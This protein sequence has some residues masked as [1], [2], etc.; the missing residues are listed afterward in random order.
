MKY[1]TII[2]LEV[3]VELKTE[4]KLCCGCSTKF[5]A[6]PNT[7]TCPVCLGLPGAL[8]VLNKKA[9]DLGITAGLA[10]NCEI[11][12]ESKFDRKQYFYPD[13]P[14][15]YQ[16]TQFYAPIC[17]TGWLE[18]EFPTGRRRIG[19]TRI[20]LEE[21]AG[22]SYHS[23]TGIIDSDYSLLDYNRSSIPL[24][25]IVTAPDLRSP[26][27]AKEFME[28]LKIILEY[29]G[30]SDCKMEEG[31]LR[32]DA[33]I[34]VRRQGDREL[35]KRAEVKNMNSFRAVEAALEYEAKRQIELLE[36][37]TPLESEETRAW[38]EGNRE[39]VFMRFKEKAY[40]YRYFPDPDLLPVII[41]DDWIKGIRNKL[42]ELPNS[43][44]ERYIQ[45]FRLPK[46]DAALISSSKPMAEF[47]EAVLKDYSGEPKNVSNWIIGDLVR[48]INQEKIEFH[49][50]KLKPE[51]LGQML[52]ILDQGVISSKIAK[53]VFEEMFYTGNKPEIIIK[54]QGLEQIS[55]VQLIQEIVVK[56][57]ADHP[58][59]IQDYLSGKKKAKSFLV[60]QVMKETK[61]KANPGIVNVLL[62][63][64]LEK[65]KE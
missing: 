58:Q 57:M 33:N 38:D 46:D 40:E 4:S 52:K 36:Q 64:E 53:T 14:K 60:G 30:V 28:E 49:Q 37:N 51:A 10:L 5:P 26:R 42:P 65:I 29:T 34:S 41:N 48:L 54:E 61:G 62:E 15:G 63:K 6:E 55:D 21:E 2:G 32:C 12:R 56:V 11:S 35:G 45:E 13:L 16:I 23:G 17:R 44:R 9:I 7:L 22:R 24:I 50:I 20:H 59:S 43:K 8:P 27:E 3:H 47:F 25:E 39:T 18:M 19:I 31:S 1:E